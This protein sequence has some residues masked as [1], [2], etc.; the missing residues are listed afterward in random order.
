[1]PVAADDDVVVDH[2]PERL[3]RLG[4]VAAGR[5]ACRVCR[6]TD[7]GWRCERKRRP[8]PNQQRG[9]REC[10][11]EVGGG[12]VRD[13]GERKES[14]GWECVGAECGGEPA[15][16]VEGDAGDGLGL[17]SWGMDRSS[18]IGLRY[19]HMLRIIQTQTFD[20]S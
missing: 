15:A 16:E 12:R 19:S 3:G 5:L 4:D 7:P 6:V 1:M 10:P 13:E 9:V 18:Y 11:E 17:S 20:D 14:D 2:D 8:G